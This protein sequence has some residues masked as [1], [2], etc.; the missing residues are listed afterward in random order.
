MHELW[1][2]LSLSKESI[3]Y[4]VLFAFPNSHSMLTEEVYKDNN[5]PPKNILVHFDIMCTFETYSIYLLTS[6]GNYW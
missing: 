3:L 1:N 4:I 2:L 6:W 5:S